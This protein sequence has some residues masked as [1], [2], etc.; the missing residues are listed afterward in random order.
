MPQSGE[1]NKAFKSFANILTVSISITEIHA[2][3]KSAFSHI[4]YYGPYVNV[5]NSLV[6]GPISADQSSRMC[7]GLF[8]DLAFFERC[9]GRQ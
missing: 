8:G 2:P 3:V 4:Y 7:E 1:T 9:C 5:F 6:P